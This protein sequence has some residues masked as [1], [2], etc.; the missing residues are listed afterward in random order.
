MEI[1]L[2]LENNAFLVILLQP[3]VMISSGIVFMVPLRVPALTLNFRY[4]LRFMSYLG[5]TFLDC[6]CNLGIPW[7]FDIFHFNRNQFSLTTTTPVP[8]TEMKHQC[9]NTIMMLNAYLSKTQTERLTE[10]LTQLKTSNLTP[11][12]SAVI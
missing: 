9:K 3:L 4:P 1:C 10:T 12:S 6:P 5:K 8:T 2:N 11:K 7:N